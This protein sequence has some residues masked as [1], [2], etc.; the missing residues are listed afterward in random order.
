MS[1]AKKIT[2][3]L[4]D[5]D[6]PIEFY[7]LHEVHISITRGYRDTNAHD[8]FMGN[9][10]KEFNGIE[11]MLIVC[12]PKEIKE[13]IVEAAMKIIDRKINS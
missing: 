10:I 1:K 12:A 3:T 6:E 5:S 13:E 7:P 11:A 2:V 9:A 4:D 8:T